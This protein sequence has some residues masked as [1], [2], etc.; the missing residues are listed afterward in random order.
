MFRF[1]TSQTH[2]YF[3]GK[4]FN[5]VDVVTMSSLLGLALANFV[6]GYHEQKWIES[7]HGRLVKFDRMY[8]DDTF[9]RFKSD[10]QA[11]TFPKFLNIQHPNLEFTIEKGHMRQI[12]F[13]DILN[14]CSDRLI[15]S[16]YR[17][18]T[19]T[20]L[21]Q[22]QNRFVA[23]AYIKALIKTL[24]DRTFSLNNT[25]DGFE[26]DLQKLKIKTDVN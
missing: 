10:H 16:V 20:G 26:L 1:T 9:C 7:D 8:V 4:I 5:Q 2:F 22:N 25:W 19:S 6:M 24:T 23:F 12:P 17:K 11:L 21:L 13:L 3:D 18:G 14:P 15:T